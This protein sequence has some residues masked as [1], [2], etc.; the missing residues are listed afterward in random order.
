MQEES[1]RKEKNFYDPYFSLKASKKF[2][3]LD[4]SC[5][6]PGCG[7][8]PEPGFATRIFKKIFGSSSPVI[9]KTSHISK[10]DHQ[11]IAKKTPETDPLCVSDS[12][13]NSMVQ[14]TI[15]L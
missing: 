9:K 11:R 8:T 2:F 14:K 10:K 6:T 7:T 5:G 12:R 1:R 13:G 4:S 3:R 15:K